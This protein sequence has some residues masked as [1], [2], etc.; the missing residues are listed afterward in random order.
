[1][2]V[3]PML[4]V[5]WIRKPIHTG[6]YYSFSWGSG[7]TSNKIQGYVEQN[8]CGMASGWRNPNKSVVVFIA[9]KLLCTLSR[10][11][12][13]NPTKSDGEAKIP[14]TLHFFSLQ[15]PLTKDMVLL[16]PGWKENWK[17][18][19]QWSTV[20]HVAVGTNCQPGGPVTGP[21]PPEG[22]AGSCP[23]FSRLM[24]PPCRNQEGCCRAQQ[25]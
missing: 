1:M 7:K 4:K 8:L 14:F 12:L 22:L 2:A 17:V 25:Y 18:L 10:P 16:I 3:C 9:G 13:V 11:F 21:V 24:H 15:T 6:E 19:I 23:W 20:A 5:G